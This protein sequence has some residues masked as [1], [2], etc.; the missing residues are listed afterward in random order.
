MKGKKL[1]DGFYR[2]RMATTEPARPAIIA[3]TRVA[4]SR[5]AMRRA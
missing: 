2:R 1:C 5:T 3:V 4:G